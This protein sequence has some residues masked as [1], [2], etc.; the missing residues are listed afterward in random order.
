MRQPKSSKILTKGTH[1][2]GTT[3]SE[4]RLSMAEQEVK[5]PGEKPAI[6]NLLMGHSITSS[7]K[8]LVLHLCL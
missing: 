4:L 6:A 7:L 1:R 3:V 8:H 2:G 5:G